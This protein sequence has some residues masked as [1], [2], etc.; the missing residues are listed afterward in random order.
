LFKEN[1]QFSL[2]IVVFAG[3]ALSV[4]LLFY[5]VPQN[6]TVHTDSAPLTVATTTL[7]KQEELRSSLPV[8]LKIPVINVDSVVEY[9]GF[10][11]NGIMDV[12]K[13]PDDAAWFKFGPR[14]GENGSAVMAGHYG[15][16]SGRA[17]AFD[18]LYKLRK[19][20]KLYIEDDKGSVISFVVRETRRYG[21]GGDDSYV[22][23]SSDGKSHLNLITCEGDWD[24]VSKSYSERL[25][26]FADKE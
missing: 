1:K 12:P 8:R 6:S 15:W 22:F 9:T 23:S 2:G 25:V 19:G 14:P 21:P 7:Y 13:N 5:F 10:A 18:N 11:S 16:N 20:D 3:L 26:I 17:A 4:A 24:K